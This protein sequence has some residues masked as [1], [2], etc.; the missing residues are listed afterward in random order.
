MQRRCDWANGSEIEA[1]YHDREWGVPCFDDRILFEFLILESAQA[2]LS[3]VTI[4]KKREGYREAFVG[5]DPQKVARFTEAEVE[6]L[7]NNPGIV[8]NR[9]KIESAISNAACFLEA[10]SKYGSFATFYW[11]FADGRPIVNG[12]RTLAEVPAKSEL[13]DKM[14]KEFKRLGFRFLGSTT[15]YAMM[16]ATGM[17]N[18]HLT[19]CFRYTQ[20]IDA[21]C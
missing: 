4:L 1:A 7:L 5:F 13:S 8:R 6:R 11:G 20:C 14:A 17:V 2:G 10:V 3:W 12:W 9:K 21:A 15:L 19:S 18:D 16:Q